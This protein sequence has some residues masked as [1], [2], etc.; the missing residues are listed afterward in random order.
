MMEPFMPKIKVEPKK[1][2]KKKI[3]EELKKTQVEKDFDE[4]E[5][6]FT[7]SEITSIQSTLIIKIDKVMEIIDYGDDTNPQRSVLEFNSWTGEKLIFARE[8]L[9]RYSETLGEFISHH[10]SRSD[11]AYIWRKG[12][13]AK[14]WLPVKTKLANT[15]SKVTNVEVDTNLTK[16]YLWE[17]YYSMFHRRRADFLVRKMEAL[18]RMIRTI[19]HRLHELVRQYRLPQSPNY[20][21][22]TSPDTPAAPTA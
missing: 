13:Y 1:E 15:L 12:A 8:R 5:S 17:Q 20:T 7:K 22:P 11:F 10:E 6:K 18:D 4:F 16:K 21:P 2:S 19:D 9:A 14:D 3:K